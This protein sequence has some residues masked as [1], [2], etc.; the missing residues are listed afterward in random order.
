MT[1]TLINGQALADKLRAD[2]KATIQSKGI[3]PRLAILLANNNPA[4]ALYV[5]RKIK[6]CHHVGIE[7]ILHQFDETVTPQNLAS[8]IKTLNDDKSINALFLQLPTFKHLDSQHLI[9]LIDPLKDVDGLTHDNMGRL[10]IG[11]PRHIPCTPQGVMKLFEHENIVLEGKHCVVVGASLLFGKPMG[12]LLLQA[13]ATLT[14]CHIKTQNLPDHTRQADILIVATGNPGL[15]KADWVKPGAI[16]IDVGVSK[17]KDGNIVGDV[18]FNAVKE[19]AAAITPVPGSVGPMTVTY[20][21]HNT[22][23][24]TLMQAN[25][26]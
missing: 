9:Q 6:A 11:E 17:D 7:P 1:A 22:V 19:V 25:I 21:L 15:I 2:I 26:N 4:S 13:N 3:K 20:L 12:Q 5:E 10:M 16:V 24:A 14:Q 8:L 18:D 23:E